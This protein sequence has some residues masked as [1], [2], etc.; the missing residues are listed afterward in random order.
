VYRLRKFARRNKGVLMAAGVVAF[1]VLLT[2]AG[3]AASTVLVLRANQE[4][5]RNLYYQHIALAEREWSANNLSG[6]EQLLDA[7]PTDLRGWEWHYLR[8]LR[9][10][11]LP[12]MEHE[13]AVFSVA[14]SPDGNRLASSSQDGIVKIWDAKT[15]QELRRIPAHENHVR[16]IAFSRDGQWLASGSWDKTVRI[17]NAQTGQER[18]PPLKGHQLKVWSVAFS[19]DGKL[20]AS[21]AGNGNPAGELKL[22]SAV[23]GQEVRSFGDP[24]SWVCCVAFSPDGQHLASGA[25]GPHPT[26]KLWDIQTGQELW[27]CHPQQ[28][29]WGVAFSR[30]GR[31]L[32]SSGGGVFWGGGELNVWDARTG[33]LIRDLHQHTR[34]VWCLA[35]SPEGRRLASASIDQ[36]V[37][38]WDVTS[39]QEALTLRGHVADVRSVVFS[40]DG[41][42]LY[43]GGHDGT[44]R[45]W[46]ATPLGHQEDEDCLTLPGHGDEVNSVAFHP[47]DPAVVASASI[48]GTVTLWNTRTALPLHNLHDPDGSVRS[49]AFSPDGQLLATVGKGGK[50]WDTN[51]GKLIKPLNDPLG[52]DLSV[53]FLPDGRRIA[54]AGFGCVVRIWDLGTGKPIHRLPGHTWGIL[55]LAASPDGRYVASASE[56]GTVRL[57]DVESGKE[58]ASL[59]LKKRADSSCV[60]FSRDGRQLASLCVDGSVMVWD[61]STWKLLHRL[62]NPAGQQRSVAFSPDRRCVAW[63]G[64]DC[65]VKVWRAGSGEPLVLRGHTDWVHS[66]AFSPD[67]K[68]IASG[69]AD[70]TVKIWNVPPL[71]KTLEAIEK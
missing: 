18:C 43:S 22:W 69:S 9:Y 5:R 42:R 33:Q 21:G 54:S 46:D 19:P 40:P 30:D 36:T 38:I 61:T 3:L 20:V 51:S 35:F 17:W 70:G 23:T 6:M 65:T 16:S 7:C 49:L 28:N 1:A 8:R 60:V 52:G 58:A 25:S 29:V 45:V 27:T 34:G 55:S 26:I 71:G 57:W 68:Q 56:D 41:H 47:R 13:G 15:G 62:Q 39:G 14:V 12:L 11:A 53:T 2:V 10:K 31:L 63:G 37:K 67:G 44:V 64:L 66:V 50:I 24:L 59:P 4:L 32:A 48:D